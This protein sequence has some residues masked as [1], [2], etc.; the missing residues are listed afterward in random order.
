MQ[1]RLLLNVV[2][3]EG[4]AI[5]ELLAGKD[6]ALL[7]RGDA[8]LVLDLGLDVVDG[9]RGLNLESDGLSSQ[10]LDEDLQ[11][12]ERKVSKISRH[13]EA[14]DAS[15]QITQYRRVIIHETHA[16]AVEQIMSE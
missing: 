14:S 6:E 1:G 16:R 7:V 12:I 11:R 13:L 8:L 4:A 15:G 9:I 3:S 10:S 2:V 5:L